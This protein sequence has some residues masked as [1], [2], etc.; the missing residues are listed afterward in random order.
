LDSETAAK[1]L[2][3]CAALANN[4]MLENSDASFSAEIRGH[5]DLIG[6]GQ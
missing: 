5:A 1:V 2:A 3:M 6:L 4:I